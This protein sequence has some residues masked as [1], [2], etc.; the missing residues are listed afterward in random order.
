MVHG[1]LPNVRLEGTTEDDG[2]VGPGDDV[3]ALRGPLSITWSQVRNALRDMGGIHDD[4]LPPDGEDLIVLYT[5]E[6]FRTQARAIYDD[7]VVSA[8]GCDG[9]DAPNIFEDKSDSTL[10]QL[11]FQPTKV[12]SG[13]RGHC[14]KCETEFRTLW[15]LIFFRGQ[16]SK[17]N[18]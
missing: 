8:D 17:L 12:S 1:R 11:L 13:L 5:K 9:F 14:R 10:G 3:C 16:N 7:A 6:G 15:K 18:A 4:C 2:T